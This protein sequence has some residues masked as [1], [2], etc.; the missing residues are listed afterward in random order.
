MA[1]IQAVV[2][3]QTEAETRQLRDAVAKRLKRSQ[4]RSQQENVAAT[5]TT[6]LSSAPATGILNV[7][8]EQQPSQN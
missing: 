7:S 3:R 1:P 5:N 4:G 6:L 8:A 2:L